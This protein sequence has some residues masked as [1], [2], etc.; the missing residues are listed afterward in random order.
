MLRFYSNL[1]RQLLGE[2]KAGKYLKY[3]L[4][5]ILLVVI[6]IL[7]ALQINNW[8]EQRKMGI[9]EQEFIAG[10]KGD[11]ARDKEYIK[12]V[13]GLARGKMAVY[14]RL[15]AEMEELYRDHRAE[16]D[17]LLGVYFVSQR[18]FYPI[19]GAF[20]AAISGNEISSFRNKKF[21]AA[22]TRLYNSTYARLMDNAE[23][24]DNRWYYL[25]QKYSQIRRTGH[26]PDMDGKALNEFLNDLF[27]HYYGLEHYV[28]NLEEASAEIDDILNID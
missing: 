10:V 7:I 19:S 4:G 1:R 27:Y 12:L 26:I 15:G 25:I 17:S 24:T 6:G 5:E 14:E 2:G 13:V 16:L 3:A 20:Q 11:L 21:T 9:A 18:T 28:G 8:N 23:A 22:A